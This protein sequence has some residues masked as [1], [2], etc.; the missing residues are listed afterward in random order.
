MRA[1]RVR[2]PPSALLPF[3][4]HLPRPPLADLAPRHPAPLALR[5]HQALLGCN[6]AGCSRYDNSRRSRPT[7]R[8]SPDGSLTLLG[9]SALRLIGLIYPT[10][11]PGRPGGGVHEDI[12]SHDTVL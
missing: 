9:Q 10:A 1:W 8:P 2:D 11:E 6:L 12:T 3:P 5:R 7:V 4:L